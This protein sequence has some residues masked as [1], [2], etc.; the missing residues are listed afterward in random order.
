MSLGLLARNTVVHATMHNLDVLENPGD[1]TDHMNI[2]Q[3]YLTLA[4]H[5]LHM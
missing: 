1:K 3:I 5:S 4:A 2:S